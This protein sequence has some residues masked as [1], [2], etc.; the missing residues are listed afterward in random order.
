MVECGM[1]KT[2]RRTYIIYIYIN[3]YIY[4][5]L[6]ALYEIIIYVFTHPTH[7]SSENYMLYGL[8]GECSKGSEGY[9]YKKRIISWKGL[10]N[11]HLLYTCSGSLFG[12]SSVRMWDLYFENNK[13][14]IIYILLFA[15][16]NIIIYVFT[17]PTHTSS[18]NYML[19]GL[20]GECS[21]G[22]EGYHYKKHIISW[23]GRSNS[24]LLYTAMDHISGNS[25]LERD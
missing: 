8:Q 6:F 22:R 23:K 15:L 4:I 24:H 17:H 5:L 20:Q 1:W 3:K 25:R 10:P 18:E 19:Y 2:T 13:N 16:Y 11:S 14:N 9:H 12:K 21:K 7:T